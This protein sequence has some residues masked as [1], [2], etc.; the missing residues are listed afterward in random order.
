MR[1]PQMSQVAR[2]KQGDT[3]DILITRVFDAPRE[4][5]WKEWTEPERVIRWWGPKT[6]TSPS[7][8]MD[9][10]VGGQY[11]SCM[12]SS[13]GK[14]IWSTGTYTEV[15]EPERLAMTDSFADAKGN[16]VPSSFYGMGGMPMELQIMVTFEEHDGKT[17]MMLRHSG[18]HIEMAKDAEQ[19]WNESFDKL[20]QDMHDEIFVRMKT[21]VLAEPGKQVATIIRVQ[22]APRKMVF[23]AQTDPDLFVQFWGPEQYTTTVDKMDIRQGGEW[24]VIQ[25][26]LEGNEFAFRGVYHTV[27]SPELIIDTWEFEGMPDHLIM[28]T[29]KFEEV[30]GRTKLTNISSFQSVDDRDGMYKAGMVEG[31]VATMDRLAKLLEKLKSNTPS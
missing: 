23:K 16:I 30:E 10:R 3:K 26:D 7:A 28:E 12:R 14:D 31:A 19:G 18:M 9:V 24:R 21:L 25:R 1:N 29:I 27:R 5:V 2:E 11:L 6:Y 4:L 22:D 20:A 15:F 8:E 13:E 17:T